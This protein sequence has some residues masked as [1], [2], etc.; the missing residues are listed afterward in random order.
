MTE[1]AS[2]TQTRTSSVRRNLMLLASYLLVL[3]LIATAYV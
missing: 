1:A 3:A 2:T